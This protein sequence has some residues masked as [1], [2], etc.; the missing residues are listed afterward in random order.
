MTSISSSTSGSI[1]MRMECLKSLLECPICLDVPR[2]APIYQCTSGHIVCN[3]CHPRLSF[4][5]ICRKP[6]LD[7]NRS[8]IAEK[9]LEQLPRTCQ[10][11]EY[12]CDL[13]CS[14]EEIELHEEECEYKLVPCVHLCCQ[15]EVSLNYLLAHIEIR[16]NLRSNR[17]S[18]F[19]EGSYGVEQNQFR[20]SR[21]VSWYPRILCIE[22]V[23]FVTELHRSKAGKWTLWIYYVG[24]KKNDAR[25]YICQIKLISVDDED[26]LT[27][28]GKV[29]PVGIMKEDISTMG[30]GLTFSDEM[31]FR[32]WNKRDKSIKYSVKVLTK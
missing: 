23:K 6:L 16:H 26:E 31:A 22:E 13:E 28:S 21:S 7:G 32:F 25:K 3:K 8:R 20:S 11:K 1:T 24:A 14:K 19:H 29:V 17:G 4:C 30:Y 9:M 12:G 18:S 10:F 15:E 27:Y 5:G 2:S